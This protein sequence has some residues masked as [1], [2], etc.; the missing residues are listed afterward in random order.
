ER[1]HRRPARRHHAGCRARRLHPPDLS[2]PCGGNPRLRGDRRAPAALA[3]CA[4]SDRDDD[5]RLQ[6][7]DRPRPLHRRLHPSGPLGA[8]RH[9]AQYAISGAGPLRRRAG[10]RLAAGPLRRDELQHTGCVAD[11]GGADP[12]PLL[13][14]DGGG[15]SLRCGL[16]V[17]ARR[18]GDR[19]LP[20]P[21]ADCRRHP[22]RAEPG[23]LVRGGAGRLR[24]GRAPLPDLGDH[25]R[26]PHRS[27]RRGGA[28]PL[29]LGRPALL[30]HPQ[31]RH[32]A[33]R[34]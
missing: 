20:G 13:R 16:L 27:T 28:R 24:R 33:A 29:R 10:G 17:L 25:P 30:E 32:V 8:E 21:R 23:G 7:A 5:D 22:L 1:D 14:V 12:L 2:A 18:A 19:R 15:F 4:E 3:R 9:V 31:H 6:L 34:V 26:L 11:G